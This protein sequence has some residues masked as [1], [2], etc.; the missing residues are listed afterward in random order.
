MSDRTFTRVLLAIAVSFLSVTVTARPSMNGEAN[1][2]LEARDSRPGGQTDAQTQV[3]GLSNLSAYEGTLE[4]GF[5][6]HDDVNTVPIGKC[7]NP[8]VSAGS[9]DPG[10]PLNVAQP[11]SPA[12]YQYEYLNF[13]SPLQYAIQISHT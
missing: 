11:C 13:T 1:S 9:S 12:T 3:L 6:I 4:S 2:L 5:N 7:N 10:V 8:T